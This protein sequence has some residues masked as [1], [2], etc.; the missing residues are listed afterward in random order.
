M[1]LTS[2]LFVKVAVVL[3]VDGCG[4]FCV[5]HRH[6]SSCKVRDKYN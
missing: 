3:S 2:E 4:R 6:D 5:S 1:L